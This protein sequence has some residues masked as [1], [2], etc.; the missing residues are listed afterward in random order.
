MSPKKVV[1]KRSSKNREIRLKYR[2]QLTP[3]TFKATLKKHGGFLS[4]SDLVKALG[5]NELG[6]MV[7][8]VTARGLGKKSVIKIIRRKHNMI[9]YALPRYS[10]PTSTA[11]VQKKLSVEKP[12]K[13]KKSPAPVSV[14]EKPIV[15]VPVPA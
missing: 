12:K 2:K 15:E 4:T 10:G 1:H 5:W 14:V 7:V 8:R 11:K 6:Y 3:E 9:G 13:Q